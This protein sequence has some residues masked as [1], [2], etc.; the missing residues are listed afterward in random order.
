M[1]KIDKWDFI[2]TISSVFT[3]IV[4]IGTTGNI[5]F[6]IILGLIMFIF[7]QNYIIR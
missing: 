6:G 4:T 3:G 7:G 5:S 1:R 2:I